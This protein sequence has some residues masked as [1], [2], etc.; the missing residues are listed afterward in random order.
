MGAAVGAGGA[1]PGRC[2]VEQGTMNP[3]VL[4]SGTSLDSD[5]V[6]V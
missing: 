6:A 4:L 3:R 5:L 2:G 1:A